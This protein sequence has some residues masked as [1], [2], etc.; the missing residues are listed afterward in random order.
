[1]FCGGSWYTSALEGT[2]KGLAMHL[3]IDQ[4]KGARLGVSWTPQT[5]GDIRC[6]LL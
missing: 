2:L 3:S 1:M 4:R 6:M 5:G